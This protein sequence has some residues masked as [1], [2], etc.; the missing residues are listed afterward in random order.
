MGCDLW[1]EVRSDD[2]FWNRMA[3]Y[4]SLMWGS[5]LATEMGDDAASAKYKTTAETIKPT[6]LAHWNGEYV[7]ESTNREKDS[8]VIHAFVELNYDDLF[9]M[10]GKEVAGTIDTL[11]HLFCNE[12]NIN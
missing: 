7:Y 9:D 4:Q 5:Q 2:F 10:T 3:F 11:N 6:V 8:A 12:Y 1:E